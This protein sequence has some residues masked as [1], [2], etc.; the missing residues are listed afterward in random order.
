MKLNYTRHGLYSCTLTISLDFNLASLSV[1]VARELGDG[2][3]LA[4]LYNEKLHL[5]YTSLV[6][7]VVTG[8]PQG[9]LGGVPGGRGTPAIYSVKIILL[10][11]FYTFVI[12]KMHIFQ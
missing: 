4:Q 6:P 10:T 8:D 7:K 12:K 2:A 1:S 3:R 5:H 9:S 11:I